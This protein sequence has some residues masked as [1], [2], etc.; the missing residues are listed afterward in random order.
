MSEF[1][2]RAAPNPLRGTLR[3]PAD[4]SITHRAL[5]LAP[6]LNGKT[7][8][9]NFL[10]S[11]T[12]RATLNC[13]RAMGADIQEIDAHTLR[14]NGRGLRSLQEPRDI[15]YCLGSGTTIRL[16][17]GICAGQHFLS[18]LDGTPALKRRPMGR[19]VEPLKQ[20]GATILARDNDRFPPLVFRGGAL[21]GIEYALP[22]ASAQVKS[23][24]LFAGLFADSPTTVHEPAPSRDHTERMLRALGVDVSRLTENSAR[25][26]PPQRLETRDW[27]L[28]I[29]ADFSSA[30]FFIVAALLVKN[31]ELC[32]ENVGLNP[33][34]TG[35]FD[36]LTRMGATFKIENQ[37]AE[38]D[39]PVG[40]II[41]SSGEL[42][43]S[44]VGG[45]DVPRMIDEFPIFAVAAT[46]AVGETRVRDAQELR[47]K[48]SDRVA[49]V[50]QELR[51][52]GAQLE[53]Q[54]DGFVIAGPTKL[55][56]ARVNAHN[57]HRLAM[58]LAVAGVIAEGETIIEGWECVADSFP[59]FSELL[60]QVSR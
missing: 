58:S 48:E 27:S 56:G 60:L 49:T 41:V 17:A 50:A 19:I 40:D 6:L 45:S 43:A 3:V 47:I 29:P 2:S 18:V 23:A 24:I 59:N 31:S 37:R 55:R 10:D 1:F 53:E 57:D 33:G 38:N 21:R 20:M 54:E 26:V 8:I 25:V 35:L 22:V 39:E 28:G 7:R 30:A 51:K 4:K 44:D 9:E 36:A 12:T 52:M 14:V 32:L 15:L 16:L 46:Q 42:R 34:R 11:E 5:M 13:M